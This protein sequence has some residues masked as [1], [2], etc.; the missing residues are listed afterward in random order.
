MASSI[1]RVTGIAIAAF[2]A[3]TGALFAQTVSQIV[4]YDDL[5]ARVG[6]ANAPTG[7]GVVVSQVEALESPGNYGPNPADSEFVGKTFSAQSGPSGNSGHATLVGENFYG[8]VSSIAPGIT[9]IFLYEAGNW[10]Q[11][12]YLRFGQ[13]GPNPPLATPNGIKVTN[14]SW[15]ATFGS[16]ASDNEVLRRADFAIN[17]DELVMCDG[18]PNPP[19]GTATLM[20]QGFNGISVGLSNGNHVWGPTAA[21]LDGPGRMKPDITAPSSLTSFATPIVSAAGADLVQTARTALGLATN[22]NAQRSEVLKAVLL[23][24]AYK[25]PTWSNHPST[26]GATRGST[27]APLDPV[28]GAGTVNINNSHIILT[29]QEQNGT[30]T[31]PT[32]TNA[33]NRGWDYI[34]STGSVASR[35]FRFHLAKTADK[36]SIVTTWNRYVEPDMSFFLLPNFDLQLWKVNASNQLISLVGAGGVGVFAGGNVLSQSTVD[37]V[38]QLYVTGLVAGDYVLELR[39]NDSVNLI[40]DVAVAWMFPKPGDVTG[41]NVVNIDDL[42]AVINNWGTCPVPSNCPADQD[43]NGVVNIDDLLIVINNWG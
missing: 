25:S 37:N 33:T 7:A 36:V 24:G 32:S 41:N 23:A 31:V 12:G 9:S 40:W 39:R 20:Y 4:G 27:A 29:G 16:A 11:P 21:T 1:G 18:Q 17:R 2:I 43:G 22:P 34:S 10:V 42:L 19:P 3:P 35:Y 8:T 15:I 6:A 28:F 30:T 5:K 38:E 26:S 14:N 13:G